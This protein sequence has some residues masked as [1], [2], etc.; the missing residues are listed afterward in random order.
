MWWS[1]SHTSARQRLCRPRSTN[2][3]FHRVTRGCTPRRPGGR[4]VSVPRRRPEVGYCTR[5]GLHLARGC[6]YCT[7][8]RTL[9]STPTSRPVAPRP[10]AVHVGRYQ[11]E[12]ARPFGDTIERPRRPAGGVSDAMTSEALR[13]HETTQVD[14]ARG[15]R[16]ASVQQD[17]TVVEQPPAGLVRREGTGR[18]CQSSLVTGTRARWK[19]PHQ[20]VRL[21]PPD[22]GAWWGSRRSAGP[23]P[24]RDRLP[25]GPAHGTRRRPHH[26]LRHPHRRRGHGLLALAP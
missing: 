9:W 15:V 16:L 1:A 7:R 18:Y 26:R 13:S 2:L 6:P 5:L 14:G 23:G 10:R 20:C 12:C 19:S 24:R 3:G 11:G 8:P 25:G 17:W 22:T 4:S 21:A